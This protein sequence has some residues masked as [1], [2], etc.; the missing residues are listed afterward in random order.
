MPQPTATVTAF[1]RSNFFYGLL[2][3]AERLQKDHAFFNGKRWLLNRLTTGSGVVCGLGVRAIA[4]TPKKWVLEPGVAID[5]LGREIV[6]AADHAFDPAQPTDSSGVAA[7][8]PLTAGVVEICLLYSEVAT[9]LVPVLVPDCDGEGE[10][11]PS[12]IREGFV[13][14]VRA[15]PAP[16]APP[17]CGLPAFPVP[18]AQGLHEILAQRLAGACPGT[19]SEACV[20]V[21][22]VD[23]GAATIDTTANRTLVYSNR[24]LYELIVCLAEHVAATATRVLRYIS[25][26]GQSGAGGAALTAPLEVELVDTLGSPVAGE[27]VQFTVTSGGG[28]VSSASVT[29]AANGR[30]STTW[31]LGTAATQ[32]QVTATATGTSFA[33][34][35][36][37]TS[38]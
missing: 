1:E 31:T 13:V 16:A 25:G 29:T 30:A 17:A 11:A 36:R 32:Q 24:V 9:D 33:V 8:A 14:V 19:P 3:D 15:A 28:T 21:A 7:G 34:T 37:A 23:L 38:V 2:L 5:G 6:V 26:D 20:P 35:F 10:C 4:G 18:P 12:T 27:A 22:R